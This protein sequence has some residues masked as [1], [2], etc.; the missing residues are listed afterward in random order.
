[1]YFHFLTHCSK[2]YYTLSNIIISPGIEGGPVAIVREGLPN[3]RA[4][5]SLLLSVEATW[6]C[7]PTEVGEFC[8]Q[9]SG[10]RLK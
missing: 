9:V 4:D 10:S 5:L 8:L 7:L 2:C 6:V 3:N 1:M